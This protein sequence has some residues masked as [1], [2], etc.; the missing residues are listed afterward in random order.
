[1]LMNTVGRRIKATRSAKQIT[2]D[3]LSIGVQL[4]GWSQ[5]DRFTISKIELGTRRVTDRELAYLCRALGA[6]AD[7]LLGLTE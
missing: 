3:E 6:S 7:K 4:L 5:C 2:Q 1:M